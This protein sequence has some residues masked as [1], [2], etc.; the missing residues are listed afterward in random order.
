MKLKH[1]QSALSSIPTPQFPS[2][3]ITLEQYGTSAELASHIIHYAL[4]NGDIGP[5]IT[6][7]ATGEDDGDI[8]HDSRDGDTSDS[9]SNSLHDSS[10]LD[11][12]CGT[13]ML[14]IGCGIVGTKRI[15][16]VDCDEDAIDIAKSN[17]EAM[18]LELADEEDEDDGGC[19]V[20][21]VLAQLKHET[22]GTGGSGNTSGRGRGRGG[23]NKGRSGHKGRGRGNSRGG[24]RGGRA[25]NHSAVSN[26]PP[27]PPT[28]NDDDGIPIQSN[29]VTTVMTNPPFG[30]KHNA[31]IDISFLKT[32]IR[33]ATKAV[34]SFHKTSTR[35][36]L[37]KTV[38]SW[39]YD[40]EVIAQM[41]FDIPKMYKFHKLN[42]VDVEVDLI[43]VSLLKK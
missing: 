21:F 39:G 3:K 38:Q 25:I 31:G 35:A 43:R 11:L 22:I 40:V 19:I 17:V 18:E 13:G 23:G 29:I 5:T 42:E 41:K 8:I 33:L 12:G 2:P 37:V 10:V 14:A 20:E 9:I 1:I 24:G 32:A 26:P 28:D 27:L 4:S 36:Y 6:N 16:C 15:I 7:S 34:Y 30:T